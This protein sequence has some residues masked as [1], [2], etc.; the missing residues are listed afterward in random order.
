M[1]AELYILSHTILQEF[2]LQPENSYFSLFHFNGD[3]K[4]S[5]VGSKEKQGTI[6]AAELEVIGNPTLITIQ[7]T[8][9]YR[10]AAAD[11]FLLP[12]L[13]LPVEDGL[14]L[15][16]TLTMGLLTETTEPG[17]ELIKVRSKDDSLNLVVFFDSSRNPVVK[18]KIAD[19]EIVAPSRFADFNKNQEHF[20]S[21]SVLP[22]EDY[23]SIQWFLDG[24]QS[25]ASRFPL[26]ANG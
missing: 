17:G 19:Q 9:G 2:D 23:I 18:I 5:G 3:L 7:D 6:A 20:I 12:R 22:R 14:L 4:D 1:N 8:V 15:P 26:T 10:L 16:F 11:G 13:I 21:L 24:Y 25:T